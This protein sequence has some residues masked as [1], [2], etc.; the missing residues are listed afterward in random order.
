[1]QRL[2]TDLIKEFRP[3]CLKIAKK[4]GFFLD[5]DKSKYLLDIIAEVIEFKDSIE[6]ESIIYDTSLDEAG[7]EAFKWLYRHRY[8]GT[9][10]SELADIF[11][12]TFSYCEFI[13][14]QK[15]EFTTYLNT[16]DIYAQLEDLVFYIID[17]DFNMVISILQ[18]IYC[19]LEFD[20][21]KHIGMKIRYNN[22]R[23]IK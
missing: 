10:E 13:K 22:L 20:I 11:I 18:F 23:R 9:P 15:L 3:Q 5:D 14:H 1:M 6:D 17:Q 8:Q 16:E 7:D 4:R 21:V 19:E 2:T 12:S